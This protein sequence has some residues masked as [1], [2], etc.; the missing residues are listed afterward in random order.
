MNVCIFIT[1]RLTLEERKIQEAKFEIVTSEA[2][3]LNS[4]RVLENEFV[5][6]N[7]LVNDIL[8]PIERDKLFGG[9]PSVLMASERFLAEME[10]VW[11][12]DPMLLGLPD[13][14]L[15]HAE[16]CLAIYAS[17]C[18]SQVSIDT[19]LKELR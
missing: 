18:S 3:Y 12:D 7:E 15:K 6:N 13:I 4:L 2:S 19:T 16:R 17:Y 10:N 11:I 5:N 9:V 8:S 14:L 1:E